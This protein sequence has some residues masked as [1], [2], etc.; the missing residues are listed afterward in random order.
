[1]ITG[2]L[3]IATAAT[4]LCQPTQAQTFPAAPPNCVYLKEVTTGKTVIRK[5]IALNNSNANTD[6]AVPTGIRFSSYIG[7]FIPENNARYQVD[8][9]LKYNDGSSSTV[10]SRTIQA[11]R[12]YLY[13]QPFQ[14]PTGRQP[15]QI[16]SRVTGT[17]NT[18]YR[19]SV[20]AC[21]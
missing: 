13:N 21:R 1:M 12:F 20:L 11:R 14:T 5:V 18:A 8:V 19:V 9:N 2:G 6:F 7:R 17:R 16:N 3:S 15:F 4:L 10:V